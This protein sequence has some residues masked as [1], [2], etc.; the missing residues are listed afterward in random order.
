MKVLTMKRLA[1]ATSI[2]LRLSL[3]VG[4]ALA[5]TTMSNH[6]GYAQETKTAPESLW[7][8]SLALGKGHETCLMTTGTG[9][10]LRPGTVSK[11][12][13][14]QLDKPTKLTELPASAWKVL[15][16]SSGTQAVATDYTGGVH[17]G[18]LSDDKSWKKLDTKTK[19]IR[20][21]IELKDGRVLLGTEDGKIVILKSDQ[22]VAEPIE[23][24][25]GS[26]FGLSLSADGSKILSSG[27]DGVV[28]LW[29]AA[30]LKAEKDYKV[31]SQ[32][33]WNASFAEGGKSIVTADANRRV[34]LFSTETGKLIM[35]I[36]MLPDWG[37]SV[38]MLP[39][40]IAAVTCL[41]GKLYLYD[42][43]SRL[44]V[45]EVAGPGSGLWCAALCD[46]N[47]HLVIGTRSKGAASLST[48]SWAAAIAETR[49]RA[50][51]EMPPSP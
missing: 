32:A 34:N 11:S 47:Q 1:S 42:V 21:M 45:T 40:D 46:D 23:A 51:E 3:T 16:L 39:D 37:T 25:K 33:V 29:N 14:E 27:G 20:S 18:N 24:H 41:N 31:G 4:A 28:K 30:D 6:P 48:A 44:K 9:L 26:I 8:T 5:V 35:T 2:S 50:A 49:K 13:V 22:T 12:S 10:L 43:R 36:G 19:W 15:L 7:V 38:T 17:I